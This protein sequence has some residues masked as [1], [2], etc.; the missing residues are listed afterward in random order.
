MKKSILRGGKIAAASLLL[1]SILIGAGA[2]ASTIKQLN[3]NYSGIRLEVDGRDVTP[4]DEKGATVEPFTVD[5]TTYLPLR[6]VGEA[7]GKE[8]TWDSER[9][10]VVIKDPGEAVDPNVAA[11]R[12]ILNGTPDE[13]SAY[14]SDDALYRYS[15]GSQPEP[16]TD[17]VNGAY[18][19]SADEWL[20]DLAEDF[21]YENPYRADYIFTRVDTEGLEEYS[22]VTGHYAYDQGLR[23][24]YQAGYEDTVFADTVV[25]KRQAVWT[26]NGEE[27]SGYR[28]LEFNFD[29]EGNI[30]L[31]REID[32]SVQEANWLLEYNAGTYASDVGGKVYTGADKD[33]YH[34]IYQDPDV[35][36]A[37]NLSALGKWWDGVGYYRCWM[38]F[39]L[40]T[41]DATMGTN[42]LLYSDSLFTEP[43]DQTDLYYDKEYSRDTLGGNRVVECWK[44]G[45]LNKPD[46]SSTWGWTDDNRLYVCAEDPNVIISDSTNTL[47]GHMYVQFTMRDGLVRDFREVRLWYEAMEDN[48]Y[49]NTTP[50]RNDPDYHG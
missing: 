10:T 38:R 48:F 6:A 43:T 41:E 30:V 36:S 17:E 23:N 4:K 5:G 8:V 31:I 21:H 28:F 35:L 18:E 47:G 15:Y 3:A 29:N 16:R 22:E 44:E 50:G 7:L 39:P 14:L 12:A 45:W 40:A 9:N 1:V 20:A 24:D 11:V 42:F 2:A 33:V 32:D 27:H 19:V 34:S 37:V 25:A 26:E 46:P 13:W 49:Q